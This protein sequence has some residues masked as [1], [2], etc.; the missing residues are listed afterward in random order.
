MTFRSPFF[1]QIFR[2]MTSPLF[3]HSCA[4]PLSRLGR[5][6]ALISITPTLMAAEANDG[7]LLIAFGTSHPEA[8]KA[9][10]FIGEGFAPKFKAESMHWAYT[11]AIIRKKLAGQGKPIDSIE[12]A[13]ERF[14]EQKT[15]TLRVQSLHIAAGE[16]FS[17]MERSLLRY[18]LK[19]PEAFDQ[20]LLG[21]PLLESEQDKADVIR[22]LIEECPKERKPDEALL[23]MG[24]GQKD[25]RADL[26]LDSLKQALNKQDPLAF[27]ATV[28]GSHS[29]ES[30]VDQLKKNKVKTVWLMPFMIVAGDHAINDLTGDEEDSWASRLRKEGFT[31]KYQLKGLGEMKG[32]RDIFLRHTEESE[33]NLLKVKD[34]VQTRKHK[35]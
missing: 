12:E 28:E 13:L 15:K 6:F 25:G 17:Y 16:E 11:S 9:Y 3:G 29:F 31:I 5:F 32:I 30:I 33:D 7:L 19:H 1:S 23:Y 34:Q 2:R 18:A 26:V 24:H 22:T 21:R 4:H 8:Q 10:T 14:R 35:S 27:F 20:I